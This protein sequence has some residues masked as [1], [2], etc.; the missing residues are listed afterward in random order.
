LNPGCCAVADYNKLR[1]C[2]K[3]WPAN[4]KLLMQDLRLL[5][6]ETIEHADKMVWNDERKRIFRP[7][8][9]PF[10]LVYA[11]KDGQVQD[12]ALPLGISA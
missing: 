11:C 8:W 6:T 5:N 1:Q 4:W 3:S 12:Y 2:A 10:G 9:S 7:E